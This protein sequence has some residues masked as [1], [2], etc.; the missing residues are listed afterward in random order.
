MSNDNVAALLQQGHEQLDRE[1][2]QEALQ[3]FEQAEQR[4]PENPQVLFGLGLACYRL[5]QYQESVDYLTQTLDIEPCYILALAYRGIAYR[6]LKLEEPA[7]A[8]FE[9]VLQLEP[10]THE[11]W[12]GRGLALS[13]LK[14]YE[15]AIVSYDKA[16]EI[17]SDYYY[18]WISRG[19]ALDELG[20]YE[21]AIA[22]YDKA[23]EINPDDYKIWGNR[24]LA[25]NNLG[26]YED[27]IASY[28]KALEINPNNYK[29]WGNRGLALNNLGKYEDAI[30]SY[31]KAIEI[32]PGEYGSWILR[33]FALDKLEKYEEVVTSLDQA[34]KINSHEY[35]AWNRRA[36]GLDKLGKHEEAIASY[37]KAIKINP[38]DYTAWRNKGFVLHKLGKYEEAIS[39]LD[40]ALKINPD[41]Y[42]FCI[43]R[44]CALD[45]LGKYSEALA[46]YNQAIQINPDDYTAW[47]NRGSALDKL[48]KYS[49]ALASYNQALEINSDEYSAW[50]LRGKTLNN[51]GK[52][53]EAITS[54]DKV[55]EIN[56]DDYTAWVN[57]GLVLNELGKYEK[58]LASYD[59][60]L[61]INPNEYYTW[62]NQGNA[63]FNLGKYEKALASY[64]KALEINPDGYTVLNNRS[65]VLCNLGKYSEMITSCDQA[66]EINPDYYM[67]WSN[68]GFGLYNLGQYEEALASCNKAIEINPDYYMAWSNRGWALFKL[69]RYQKAFKNWKD[70]IKNLNLDTPEHREGR[71]K[72]YYSEAQAYYQLGLKEAD[73]DNLL[74]AKKYYNKALKFLDTPKYRAQKL[75]IM[76]DLIQVCQYISTP[77]EVQE[78]LN[79]GTD[80]LERWLQD[81]NFSDE[82]YIHF[83]QKFAGF[84]QYQVDTLAQSSEPEQHIQAIELAEE[85]K[86]TCLGWLQYGKAYKAPNLTYNQIQQQL[87]SHTAAI[88]WHIS[89]AAI[90]TFILKHNQPPQILQLQ[91]LKSKKKRSPFPFF[92]QPKKS[93]P[94]IANQLRKFEDWLEQWKKDYRHYN[95]APQTT[96]IWR[97]SMESQLSSLEKILHIGDIVRYLEDIDQLIL[98]PHR[99]LHLLPLHYL[100]PSRFTITYLPSFQIGLNL[101]PYQSAQ[102]LLSLENPDRQTNYCTLTSNILTSL[103]PQCQRLNSS[104]LDKKQLIQDL[105]SNTGTFQFIGHAYHNLDNPKASALQLTIADQLTMAEI[106]DQLDFGNYN[107]IFLSACETGITNSQNLIDEYVGLVSAFLAKGASYVISTLWTVD[108]RSTALL[109][110]RFYQYLKAGKHPVYA[111]KQA[112]N[113]L[114]QVTNRDL[115]KW[116]LELAQDVKAT[117]PHASEYLK[118]EAAL[119]QQ[120]SD[121]MMAGKPP[122]DHPYHWAGFIITG[123]HF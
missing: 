64:D 96:S 100:F 32:N 17:N 5:Q 65:G 91:P 75:E 70:G 79:Q 69:K 105:K 11:H 18:A 93:Y 85:R 106:F 37:D 58:A 94:E 14:R 51:L 29:A 22:S 102:S 78:L 73:L 3:T 90:T 77:K 68:R 115:V 27:A 103:Y 16:I 10:Q 74:Q 36:I 6:G 62:N 39:S 45:K 120:D 104:S 4:E 72:L 92:N 107:L 13:E 89:P 46:S 98:I 47:I 7:T 87:N 43:L 118:T 67:A 12:R 33:S 25:L 35:Y 23:L 30:A 99:D 108:E 113:W 109:T 38:D 111:L 122:F 117:H 40:Q 71:S 80:L 63:L 24:G 42:Y 60:A 52:Y 116:Y 121:K 112:Q 41:Q 56:S 55:I 59:K 82:N 95:Q 44:G 34:L 21:N 83:K 50:N 88:Y 19:L 57:R 31:D 110:I 101:Q 49:E 15:E 28:D 84:N 97:Q 9:Q 54:F 1:Q 26:K 86:N 8:D 76:Q 53:E 119:I 81:S 114:K 2:N 123:N 48:G 20:K 61:E 66:I